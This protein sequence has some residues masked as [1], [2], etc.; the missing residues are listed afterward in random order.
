MSRP[1]D[2]DTIATLTRERDEAR[3]KFEE[4]LGRAQLH[5]E[6]ADVLREQRDEARAEVERLQRHTEKLAHSRAVVL[7]ERDG[8]ERNLAVARELVREWEQSYSELTAACGDERIQGQPVADVIR[9]L[10]ARLAKLE[11]ALRPFAVAAD[12]TD[13]SRLFA[14][15]KRGPQSTGGP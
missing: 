10:R 7:S 3:A 15:P 1:S 14:G 13:I 12:A 11:A 9:S 5:V 4:Q 8:A 2:A 6:E